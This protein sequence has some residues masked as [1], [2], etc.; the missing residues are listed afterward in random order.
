MNFP[1]NLLYTKSHE[2]VQDTGENTLRV[3]LSDF[4]QH[5]LGDL[6]FVNLPAVGDPLVMGESFA[7]VE[8]VKAVED[9]FSPLTGV[10]VAI[11]EELLEDPSLINS[12]CYDAWLVEAGEVTLKD[13]MMS[14][15]E[16]EAYT[17]EGM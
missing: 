16:Y 4:A 6:V 11:N 3:G 13:E 2:W 17:K 1:K 14:G 10:V 9:V 5:E 12:D 7:D 8:S 15:D